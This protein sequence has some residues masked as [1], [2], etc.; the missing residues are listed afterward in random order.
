MV[1]KSVRYI[2]DLVNENGR[3]YEQVEFTQKTG[4]Q[5]NFIQYNGLIQSIKQYLKQQKKEI[6]H[7]EPSPFIPS[8]IKTILKYSKGS[9]DMYYLLNKTHEIPTGQNTWNKL[10]NIPENKWKNIHMFPFRT[11]K[12]PALQWFQISINHNI[13]VTNKLLFN[14]KINN[15]ALCN[16]CQSSNESIVHLFWKCDKTQQFIRN[17]KIWLN[18]YDIHYDIN[19]GGHTFLA[20][21]F[22]DFSLIFS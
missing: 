22:P 16:F 13:L 10:Y 18:S 19:Q 5:T 6:S 14:M 11:T 20:M 8:H 21:K 3:L 15:D 9:K 17:V 2:N 12:Y 1:K 7:K 4:I